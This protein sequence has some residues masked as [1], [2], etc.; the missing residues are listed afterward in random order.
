MGLEDTLQEGWA[1]DKSSLTVRQN[2]EHQQDFSPEK[3]IS[4]QLLSLAERS[5]VRKVLVDCREPRAHP[6]ADADIPL[7]VRI[8]LSRS[9]ETISDGES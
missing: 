6:D 3:W 8:G 1:L 9:E 7:Q 4:V 2:A 5:G